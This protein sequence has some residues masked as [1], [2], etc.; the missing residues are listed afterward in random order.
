[1][2]KKLFFLLLFLGITING[3]SAELLVR[4]KPHWMDSFTQSEVDKMSAGE[5]QS[6]EAR[7]QIGDIIV[8]RPDGW[9]W[10]SEECLPNYVLVKIPQIT[11]SEAKKYE[12]SLWDKTDPQKPILLR[13]RKNNIPKLVIETYKTQEKSTV[14]IDKNVSTYISNIITKVGVASEVIQ[15]SKNI[16]LYYWRTLA[17]K[18]NPYLKTAYNFYVK[19]C[20]AAQ[21]LYKTVKPSGGDYTSLEACMNANEQNLTGDGWFD[22]EIDGTWSSADTTGVT[23]HNYI[24]TA[25]DYINI[26]TTA[27][28]RHKGIWSTSYYINSPASGDNIYVAGVDNIYIT[29]LQFLKANA[30][31]MRCIDLDA[32][33]S[34]YISKNIIKAITAN[35]ASSGVLINSNC[36]S[37]TAIF[38]NIV[39]QSG[40][41]ENF[42]GLNNWY[43]INASMYSNTVYGC[44]LGINAYSTG[45][46]IVKNN[47]C[48]NNT[49]DYSGTFGT[50]STN[51]LSKDATAPPL[52]TYYVSK[53]LTFTNTG[54]GTEDFHLVSGDTDAIDKGADTSGEGAPLNFTDDIDGVTRSGTW[55]I[56]ADEYVA[57]GGATTTLDVFGNMDVNQATDIFG[58]S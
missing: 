47:I 49:T 50:T 53:T 16:T 41:A 43:S 24:T 30:M 35:Y 51:N 33:G 31:Y 58:G 15:P 48:Y 21:F 13:H 14:L 27:A 9:V 22:V 29:G 57:A 42:T 20:Y 3:F 44:S 37:G 40:G 5:K 52:N 4:A 34:I 55:D 28:A 8:V 26:Y 1:M 23:I 19:K 12:E 56:G 2:I 17:N 54:S 18:L 11:E 32:S 10:G 6:Y 38:N 46:T 39:Y 7:S 45:T 36:G 25:V